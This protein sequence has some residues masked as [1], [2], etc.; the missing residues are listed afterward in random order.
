MAEALEKQYTAKKV[1][2]RQEE[3]LNLARQTIAGSRAE[4]TLVRIIS[5]DTALTRFANSEIHQNTF[6]RNAT[7]QISARE[8]RR[9]GVINTNVLTPE[10][11]REA[12][13]RA[14]AAARVSEPN[15][16]LADFVEGPREYPTQVDS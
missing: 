2:N 13:D 16:D 1:M 5:S 10:S 15:P 9:E 12:A 8:G 6:E 7:V 11:L 3:L 14:L 4:Q